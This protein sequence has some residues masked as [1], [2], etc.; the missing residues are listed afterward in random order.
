MTSRPPAQLSNVSTTGGEAWHD[1]TTGVPRNRLRRILR[2]IAALTASAL[3]GCT[4]LVP[5]DRVDETLIVPIDPALAAWAAADVC[6][7]EFPGIDPIPWHA[8][9]PLHRSDDDTYEV[10]IERTGPRETYRIAT[11]GRMPPPTRIETIGHVLLRPS[12]FVCSP[13]STDAAGT[14]SDSALIVV[15]PQ[16]GGSRIVVTLRGAPA[17]GGLAAHLT[18]LLEELAI[19]RTSDRKSVV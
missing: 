2:H 4:W 13:S 1:P 3:A 11:N 6:R 16:A 14:S 17:R 10:R 12:R 15:E 5:G 18:R 19:V 7:V 9:A 8:H